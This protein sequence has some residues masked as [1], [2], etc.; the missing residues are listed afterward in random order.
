MIASSKRNVSLWPVLILR[1]SSLR[2]E[3]SR[4]SGERLYS[5]CR[6]DCN[7]TSFK[8]YG[9]QIAYSLQHSASSILTNQSN[10]HISHAQSTHHFS[11][12]GSINTSMSSSF[13]TLFGANIALCVNPYIKIK[14]MDVG[15]WSLTELLQSLHCQPPQ[16][17]RPLFS[18]DSVK[19]TF[20]TT[21]SP[22]GL[23]PRSIFAASLP[24]SDQIQ[25]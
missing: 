12:V 8:C 2:K 5:A 21:I 15:I 19:Y 13:S 22:S 3:P 10:C 4:E 25:M 6:Q 1:P 14:N 11:S 17:C 18:G 16:P 7:K 23:S 20:E 24:T 9:I